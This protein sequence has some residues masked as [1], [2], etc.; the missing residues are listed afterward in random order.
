MANLIQEWKHNLESEPTKSVLSLVSLWDLLYD[1]KGVLW[2]NR[3]DGTIVNAGTHLSHDIICYYSGQYNTDGSLNMNNAGNAYILKETCKW[4]YLGIDI[5]LPK[6]DARAKQMIRPFDY[7]LKRR[8]SVQSTDVFETKKYILFDKD[9]VLAPTSVED[10]TASGIINKNAFITNPNTTL[11]TYTPPKVFQGISSMGEN[12]KSGSW[13]IYLASEDYAFKTTL[14]TSDSFRS[15]NTIFLNPY[16]PYTQCLVLRALG[17]STQLFDSYNVE[18]GDYLSSTI[19]VGDAKNIFSGLSDVGDRLSFDDVNYTETIESYLNKFTEPLN[20]TLYSTAWEELL[21]NTFVYIRCPFFGDYIKP[22]S[23]NQDLN[24]DSQV[25]HKEL[26]ISGAGDFK[27]Y[28]GLLV[29]KINDSNKTTVN[30]YNNKEEYSEYSQPYIPKTSPTVDF[31]TSNFLDSEEK[32]NEI[33]KGNT[34]GGYSSKIKTNYSGT[35]IDD[36][37][38]E[39][40]S[41]NNPII[42]GLPIAPINRDDAK[43]AV[44]ANNAD[45]YDNLLPPNYFDPESRYS[46]EDYK[47]MGKFP[48][49]LPESGNLYV[50]G[51]IISPTVDEIWYMLKK[52]VGGRPSDIVETEDSVDYTSTTVGTKDIGIPFGFDEGEKKSHINDTDTTMTEVVESE[53]N[54]T[55]NGSAEK[56]NKYGDPIG[57][58]YT[59]KESDEVKLLV[60]KFVN[61]NNTIVYP[62]FNSLKAVSN[63]ITKFDKE[64]NPRG[65]SNFTAWKTFGEPTSDVY[66]EENRIKDGEVISTQDWAPRKV[67]YS[68]R[69]L[70]AISMGNKYNIVTLSRFLKENFSIVGALGKYNITEDGTDTSNDFAGS[71]YQFHKNYN[72]EVDNPNT[73]YNQNGTQSGYDENNNIVGIQATLDDTDSRDLTAE[74][75]GIRLHKD[76][77]TSPAI[78]Y[79]QDKYSSSDVYLAA[80]GTW[81]YVGDHVR[82][83]VLKCEY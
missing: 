78:N 64:G 65:I 49:V 34:N 30:E 68:L 44:S 5:A 31:Y 67:P 12:F 60:N 40:V 50:D 41:L 42:K 82:I 58:A 73:Y 74:T 23:F 69:E 52:L 39:K 22:D 25:V 21:K 54:F 71:L 48:T 7:M 59:N 15:Y 19:K 53:F 35:N 29:Q 77:G 28:D 63:R 61:Q 1:E 38:E 26:M 47:Q 70:E 66:S 43:K 16:S 55:Y 10:F 24:S 4:S 2:I 13:D 6:Y 79:N 75:V 56:Y 3:D 8:D 9:S 32:L 37:L 51:R 72:F 33:K 81:R 18:G 45:V 80:D 27:K 36:F 76:Y 20:K 57:F 17:L 14:V 83:P 46:D 62:I 11:E